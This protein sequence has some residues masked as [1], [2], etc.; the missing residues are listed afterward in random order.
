VVG[1][2]NCE[3]RTI[4]Q[5][6]WDR[7]HHSQEK[8]MILEDLFVCLRSEHMN[9]ALGNKNTISLVCTRCSH[10][11]DK[12]VQKFG[13]PVGT[14]D[15][16]DVRLDLRRCASMGQMRAIHFEL[17]KG[18]VLVSVRHRL[19]LRLFEVRGECNGRVRI[20]LDQ[21]QLVGKMIAKIRKMGE[22]GSEFCEVT[23]CRRTIETQSIGFDENALL[24][25]PGKKVSVFA[26]KFD[27]AEAS[28]AQHLAA[29]ANMRRAL[30]FAACSGHFE[31]LFEFF[32]TDR[33]RICC[34]DELLFVAEGAEDQ[35]RFVLKH[36]P[37][38]RCHRGNGVK[39]VRRRRR[40]KVGSYREIKVSRNEI[41]CCLWCS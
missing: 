3:P 9:G 2:D 30:T 7:G 25:E 5:I 34:E 11:R 36:R 13:I 16:D 17:W 41:F 15:A 1:V 4:L 22:I 27:V 39:F 14:L 6:N 33:E 24:F 31:V 20:N 19:K 26:F 23:D 18:V 32:F 28:V 12:F 8:V 37:E 35:G 21:H 29:D 40:G 10:A 38:E